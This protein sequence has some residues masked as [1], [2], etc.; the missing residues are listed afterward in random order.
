MKTLENKVRIWSQ[1]RKIFLFEGTIQELVKECIAPDM[2]FPMFM[3]ENGLVFQQYVGMKDETSKDIFEGDYLVWEH[4]GKD[5][6]LVRFTEISDDYYPGWRVT[7]LFTQGGK[8][9]IVGNIFEK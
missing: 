5:R 8:C 4:G 3:S 6:V 2:E 1:S 7:D 9:K